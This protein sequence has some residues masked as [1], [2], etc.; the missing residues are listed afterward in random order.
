MSLIVPMKFARDLSARKRLSSQFPSASSAH[1]TI[2]LQGPP[3]FHYWACFSGEIFICAKGSCLS[4]PVCASRSTVNVERRE[5]AV[6]S[7]HRRDKSV[8]GTNKG[9]VTIHF[10]GRESI[11][12]TESRKSTVIDSLGFHLNKDLS[13]P[14]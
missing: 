10:G 7:C 14:Q 11:S 12:S 3:S 9:L 5:M 8:G 6:G 1:S 4:F 13:V 2:S